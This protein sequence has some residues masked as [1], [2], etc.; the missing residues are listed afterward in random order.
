MELTM[1]RKIWVLVAMPVLL[2]LLV[3]GMAESQTVSV[4]S[5]LNEMADRSAIA[6]LPVPAYELLQ[7]SS[8][9]ISKRDPG[10]PVTWHS[11]KDNEQ[12][13]R[14]ERN[15]GRKEW[16]IMDQDG[17]GAIVRFWLPLDPSRD[18][19]TI[20]IYLD[21]SDVPTLSAPFNDLL[22]GLSTVKSP[23][24]FTSCD[25]SSAAKQ[26]SARPPVTRGVAGDLYLPL[27]FA[28]HCKVT[29][30]QLPFYYIINYRKYSP[31]THVVSFS[32]EDIKKLPQQSAA[33]I[34]SIITG[35]SLPAIKPDRAA[36]RQG[37]I[38]P[39][40]SITLDLPAGS[41]AV[42]EVGFTLEGTDVS[43]R[44]L[45]LSAQ[46]DGEETVWCPLSE[47][48]GGG[49]RSGDVVNRY[50][51]CTKSNDTGKLSFTCH[52]VMPYRSKGTLKLI[53]LGLSPVKAD[54]YTSIA[55]W[56]WDARSMHFHAGW[57]FARDLKTRPMFDWNY[58]EIKGKA[59]YAGDTLTVYSPV[60]DW[61]GEGDERIYLNGATFPAHI[62]TGTEDYY[63][64]AWGMAD[65]FSSPWI[66]CPARDVHD[67][68]DWRGYTT[69]SRMRILDAIPVTSGLKV[70]MEIWNWADTKVDN[71]VGVFFYAVPG[72]TTNLVPDIQAV[73]LPTHSAPRSMLTKV[74]IAGA[75]ECEDMKVR[76]VSDGVA[77]SIQSA[78]LKEGGWSA[79]KQLFV[80]FTKA[81]QEITLEVPC[82]S[83][84]AAHVFLYLTQS[85]DYGILGFKINGRPAGTF[86]G[87][88]EV[89]RSA[90]PI[91]LGAAAAIDGHIVLSVAAVSSDTKGPAGKIYAGLD[92]VVIKP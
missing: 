8:H 23:L 41:H 75:L 86:K 31:G 32:S 58:A 21:G 52:F 40:G 81:E 35:N 1:F 71:A 26:V 78:G 25:G 46:F 57:R 90:G 67:R 48:M 36:L 56:S 33:Q 18:K 55:P 3:S 4:R 61:Y 89:P 66:S 76:S 53:N 80:Q 16:V 88:S 37:T 83:A 85:F 87:Y 68:G 14:T 70:D 22:A 91:D 84:T 62:G 51:I 47:L 29:L 74:E 15:A 39:G 73:K 34:S 45:V 20:R 79:G 13:I 54:A 69:T 92:C 43:A 65:A 6:R 11:N 64:Y 28:R 72:V 9:D 12:F 59:V 44:S 17:P 42:Q 60:P 50:Q 24:A 27:P 63:G 19:Q 77:T 82:K 49:V 38:S 30:D 2:V 5:L 10:D 7:V